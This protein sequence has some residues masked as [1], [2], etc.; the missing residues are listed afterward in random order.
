MPTT[1]AKTQVDN[2][3]NFNRKDKDKNKVTIIKKWGD[4]DRY[5][6]QYFDNK[7]K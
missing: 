6:D 4:P 1:R 7:E 5:L 2:E 3:I